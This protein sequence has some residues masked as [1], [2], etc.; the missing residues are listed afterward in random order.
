MTTKEFAIWGVPPGETDE[1]LLLTQ[2]KG[3]PIRDRQVAEK[4]ADLLKQRFG[5]RQVRIQ[6]LDLAE[7]FHWG[8]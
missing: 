1:N 5:A 6:E 7:E 2:V 8:R 3:E 4:L